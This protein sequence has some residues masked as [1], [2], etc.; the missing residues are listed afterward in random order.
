MANTVKAKSWLPGFSVAYTL[1][2][3]PPVIEWCTVGATALKK[4]DSVIMGSSVMTIGLSN[5]PLLYG[6]CLADG[7]IGAL[8]PVAVD[9]AICCHEEAVRAVPEIPSI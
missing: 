5:S 8:I 1:T 9:T 7:D 6:V 4:G 2:G 3:A